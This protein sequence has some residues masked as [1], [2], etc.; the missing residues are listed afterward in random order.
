MN[1]GQLQSLVSYWVD[2]PN[3]TYFTPAQVQLFL[4]N[5]QQ[6]CNKQL[7]QLDDSWY[8]KCGQ[9]NLIVNQECYALPYDFQ[10]INH[11]ELIVGGVYPNEQKFTLNH[12]T[13]GEADAVNYSPSQPI[14]FFLEKNCIIYRPIPNQAYL[15]RMY[16]SYRVTDMVYPTDVPDVPVEY[17]EY[18]AVLATLDCFLKDQRDPTPFITKRTFYETLMKSSATDRMI[19][20]PRSIV[21]T[22]DDGFGNLY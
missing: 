6:E 3:F 7:T 8:K 22:Y 11:M 20:K 2:D 18:L 4:N 15:V 21:Q 9:T 1:F 17:Q 13:Q 12:S 16:Y 5:A 19:D 14:T 10:K